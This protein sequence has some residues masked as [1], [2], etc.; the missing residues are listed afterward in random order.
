MADIQPA[1][2]EAG[3]AYIRRQ[4]AHHEELMRLEAEEQQLL[5]LH[6]G[7]TRVG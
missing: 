2:I 7:P 4:R 1:Q 5:G 3:L 6:V